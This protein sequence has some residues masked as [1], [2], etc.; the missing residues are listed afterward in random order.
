MEITLTNFCQQEMSLPMHAAQNIRFHYPKSF[1]ERTDLT[2]AIKLKSASNAIIGLRDLFIDSSTEPVI[3]QG[4]IA[5]EFR[6]RGL[7]QE[8]LLEVI[9]FLSSANAE[10]LVFNCGLDNDPVVHIAQKLG[11]TDAIPDSISEMT[12]RRKFMLNLSS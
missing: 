5:R 11:F 8:V 1:T 4:Y 10:R 6:N 12:R 3:T 9:G 2:W 7:N